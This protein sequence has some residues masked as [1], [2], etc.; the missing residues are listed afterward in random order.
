MRQVGSGGKSGVGESDQHRLQHG[1]LVSV[2]RLRF[3]M[4][5]AS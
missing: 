1:L 3:S 5:P 2:R 4:L